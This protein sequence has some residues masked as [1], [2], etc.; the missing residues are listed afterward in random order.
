MQSDL[1]KALTAYGREHKLK[2]EFNVKLLGAYIFYEKNSTRWKFGKGK[3]EARLRDFNTSRV[4]ENRMVH[5]VTLTSKNEVK[6]KTIDSMYIGIERGLHKLLKN[7]RIDNSELFNFTEEE[8]LDIL[9]L[10]DPSFTFEKRKIKKRRRD[11]TG[12]FDLQVKDSRLQR[13]RALFEPFINKTKCCGDRMVITKKGQRRYCPH[14]HKSPPRESV[15]DDIV[16][17]LDDILSGFEK[18]GENPMYTT[19]E[20]I[21]APSTIDSLVN[22]DGTP[23]SWDDEETESESNGSGSNA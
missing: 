16:I 13:I 14:C 1:A 8:I 5:Y 20:T 10:L 9:R 3:A 21:I 2:V 6:D 4:S 17:E 19:T 11:G 15:P 22:E 18:A 12:S 23:F 7:R